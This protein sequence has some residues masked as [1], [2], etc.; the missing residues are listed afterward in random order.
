MRKDIVNV[1]N[2]LADSEG[3]MDTHLPEVQF[4]RASK[5]LL[6]MPVVY[7]QC[8]CFAIQGSKSTRSGDRIM[9]YDPDNY[10]VVPTIMPF[11]CETRYTAEE[12]FLGVVIALDFPVLQEVIDAIGTEYGDASERLTP[13]PGMYLERINGDMQESLLRLLKSLQCKGEAAVLGKQMI[14]EVFYRVLMGEHGHVLASAASGESSY[15]KIA[16]AIRIIHSK[17]SESMD[18]SQLAGQVNMSVRSFH[19]HFK[20]ATNCTPFQYLKKIRLNHARRLLVIQR[21]QANV[22]AHMVGYESTSQFS[23]EFK[24]YFGYPPKDAQNMVS[25][26]MLQ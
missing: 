6:T 10:L 17:F 18:V 15:A 14:R 2:V 11:E 21:L 7:D 25:E 5:D 24:K 3:Y 12:P 20:A 13:N 4:F 19:D 26:R 8:I 23:R 16:K 1:L 9:T 22:T